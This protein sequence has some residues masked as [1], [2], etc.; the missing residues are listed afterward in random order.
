MPAPIAR[1]SRLRIFGNDALQGGLD[2]VFLPA[3][4]GGYALVGLQRPIAS[5]FVGIEWGTE[6]VMEETRARLRAAAL[7]WSEPAILWDVDRPK[8]V[9]RLLANLDP[10]GANRLL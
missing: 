10:K 7:K 9:A 5:L 6:R 1:R 8:D 2:A 4:D 3:E